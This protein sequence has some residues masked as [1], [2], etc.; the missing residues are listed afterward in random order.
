[1]G[2]SSSKEPPPPPLVAITPL[3]LYP[4]F[5]THSQEMALTVL[6]KF[7]GDYSAKDAMTRQQ[8]FSI[9]SKTISMTNKKEIVDA[10]GTP[11]LSLETRAFTLHPKIDGFDGRPLE[12]GTGP[13]PPILKVKFTSNRSANIMFRDRCNPNGVEEDIVLTFETN[14]RYTKG[15][16][17]NVKG[18]PIARM[19]P[20]KRK[21]HETLLTIAQGA[22][23]AL[24]TAICVI[25]KVRDV[26]RRNNGSSGSA[27]AAGTSGG[28]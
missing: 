16:V 25:L 14:R 17:C 7:G 9:L 28:C 11:V 15:T 21:A 27:A 10:H 22:D 8:I 5:T 12:P 6:R 1:M 13:S 24:M 23:A 19:M 2:A 18:V 3:G 4:Q 20:S 26:K